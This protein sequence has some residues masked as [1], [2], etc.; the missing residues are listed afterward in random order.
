MVSREEIPAAEVVVEEVEAGVVDVVVEVVEKVVLPNSLASSRACQMAALELTAISSILQALTTQDHHKDNPV[1][2]S[3]SPSSSN[4]HLLKDFRCPSN[5]ASL[6]NQ[7]LNRRWR[8]SSKTT[9]N[10]AVKKLVGLVPLVRAGTMAKDTVTL[11]TL[12]NLH[13]VLKPCPQLNNSSHSPNKRPR[14][15]KVE[16]PATSSSKASATWS[17]ASTRTFSAHRTSHSSLTRQLRTLCSSR[18]PLQPRHC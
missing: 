8:H 11:T 17:S 13:P 15:A 7:W 10:L 9:S 5:L 14:V 3:N 2:L 6:D 12:S 18:V 4:S 1:D 16:A